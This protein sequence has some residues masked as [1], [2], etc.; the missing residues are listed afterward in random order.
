M[1]KALGL[2][3][4]IVGLSASTCFGDDTQNGKNAPQMMTLSGA[5]FSLIDSVT[6]GGGDL[7][8]AKTMDSVMIVGSSTISPT[9][10]S[11]G[12]SGSTAAT[13]ACRITI[14]HD[15]TQAKQVYTVVV[16][17]GPQ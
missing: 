10:A 16:G 3:L 4:A 7:K 6:H 12:S 1:Y 8:A 9:A 14:K 5:T 2:M 11:S 17:C 15:P 13:D